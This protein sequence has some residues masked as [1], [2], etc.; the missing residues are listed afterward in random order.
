MNLFW[1]R[2]YV[3]DDGSKY[4]RTIYL[5][6]G[7]GFAF[8]SLVWLY[9]LFI[10]DIYCQ[11]LDVYTYSTPQEQQSAYKQTESPMAYACPR[12]NSESR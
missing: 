2:M 3:C 11:A 5:L 9:L 1:K 7:Y 10:T 8:Y 12:G 6:N 4:P